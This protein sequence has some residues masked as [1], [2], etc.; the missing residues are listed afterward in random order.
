AGFRHDERHT[1]FPC[2]ASRVS[3]A[4]TESI[5]NHVRP[6]RDEWCRHGDFTVLVRIKPRTYIH[7]KWVGNHASHERSSRLGIS[8]HPRCVM[9]VLRRLF[10]WYLGLPAPQAGQRTDWRFEFQ[11]PAAIQ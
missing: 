1:S 2:R 7:L 4:R 9:S 8:R 5:H 10:E 3:K 6:D 11:P